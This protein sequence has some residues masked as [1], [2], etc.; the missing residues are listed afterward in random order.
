MFNTY[1][2]FADFKQKD[3]QELSYEVKR[4]DHVIG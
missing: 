3:K 2:K 1:N 4:V